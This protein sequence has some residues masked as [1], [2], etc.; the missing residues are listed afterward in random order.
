[1]PVANLLQ[2]RRTRRVPRPQKPVNAIR[3]PTR[4]GDKDA[5]MTQFWR[6]FRIRFEFG[7][8]GK[9]LLARDDELHIMQ[10]HILPHAGIVRTSPAKMLATQPGKRPFISSA[11]VPQQFAGLLLLLFEIQDFLLR[12]PGPQD[13][14]K[15]FIGK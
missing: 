5:C 15:R 4:I 12:M 3:N 2:S 9:S 14:R 8:A 7:P 11:E 6:R 13:R 10:S 1:M